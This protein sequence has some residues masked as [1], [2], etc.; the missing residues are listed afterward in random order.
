[1]QEVFRLLDRVAGTGRTVLLLGEPGTGKGLLAQILH[2][3]SAV[4]RG[5]FVAFSATALPESMAESELFGHPRT[6]GGRF[7]EARGGTLFLDE[8]TDLS[9]G[10][11]D[12][13]LHALETQ[14]GDPRILAS[15]SRSL[16][17]AVGEGRLRPALAVHLQDFP[18]QVPPLRERGADIVALADHFVTRSG[19]QT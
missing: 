16:E 10:V 2:L 3:R 4:S 12:R 13:L 7:D 15:S 14:A 6:H 11:Q 18:I 9:L 5:P 1:M 17:R 19:G 8:V